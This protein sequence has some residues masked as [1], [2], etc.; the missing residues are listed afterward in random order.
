MPKSAKNQ[1]QQIS[2]QKEC[3]PLPLRGGGSGVGQTSGIVESQP[4]G[5]DRDDRAGASESILSAVSGG[6]LA[7]LIDDAEDQLEQANACI[8]WYED[9]R[10]KVLGRLENLRQLQSLQSDNPNP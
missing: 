2:E 7:Q 6:I 5:T 9:E 4:F 1:T 10:Q 8:Q 3:E